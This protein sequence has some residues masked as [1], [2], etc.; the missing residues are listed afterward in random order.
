MLFV[1]ILVFI[2]LPHQPEIAK[3]EVL[4]PKGNLIIE[5]SWP[6]HMNVDV[7]LWV[8]G[9]T[10]SPVGYSSKNGEYLDLLRDDLGRVNDLGNLNYE[11][12]YG[13]DVP[14]GDYTI[15]LH[16]YNNRN[17]S[18]WPVVPVDLTVFTD[19]N[20]SSKTKVI[21][22]HVKL[23][24]E[25]EEITVVRFYFDTETGKITDRNYVFRALRSR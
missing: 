23:H 22:E 12:V 10:S 18:E 6:D 20:S 9:P 21:Q 7:D 13:R 24:F 11:I 2:L 1:L 16:L 25:G 8:Q 15:N 14:S 4:E 5:V 19:T 17:T 3:E